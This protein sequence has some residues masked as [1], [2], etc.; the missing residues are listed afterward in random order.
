MDYLHASLD[1]VLKFNIAQK[2]NPEI[3][4]M[5]HSAWAHLVM[6]LTQSPIWKNNLI[7]I[8]VLSGIFECQVVCEISVNEDVRLS[9]KEAQNLSILNNLSNSN[10][11]Y[12][13][14]VGA[15][16]P[17]GWIDQSVELYGA[18]D[19]CDKDVRLRVVNKANHFSL[20]DKIVDAKTDAGVQ[21][22]SWIN[23]IF[24]NHNYY[25]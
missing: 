2:D 9:Q 7:G 10:L 20:V 17:S 6:H 4:L 21:L 8:V 1:K 22:Y 19:R 13:V 5:G 15:E 3:I 11:Q 24:D 14:A 18:L 25:N 12:Y 16:E 23:K